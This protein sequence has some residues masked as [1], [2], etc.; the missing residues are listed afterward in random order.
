MKYQNHSYHVDV[1]AVGSSLSHKHDEQF[2]EEWFCLHFVSTIIVLLYIVY[3]VA[4][5][6]HSN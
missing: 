5:S 2:G 4:I 3:L 6:H 1:C